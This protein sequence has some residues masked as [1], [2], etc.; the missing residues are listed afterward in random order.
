MTRGIPE[1]EAVA[2]L[3]KQGLEIVD[4]KGKGDCMP[5]ALL[6]Q[7]EADVAAPCE[8]MDSDQLRVM[9]V[10]HL[11]KLKPPE[12]KAE[13]KAE[14]CQFADEGKDSE[15]LWAKT[16]STPGQ[17]CDLRFARLFGLVV[18]AAKLCILQLVQNEGEEAEP[19][20]DWV[21]YDLV[22]RGEGSTVH[23]VHLDDNH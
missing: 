19:K 23:L 10:S 20:I 18:G 13:F 2:Y 17:P 4:N 6:K 11:E 8:G 3:E 22:Q 5:L 21:S 9:V 1:L 12:C 16:M 7:P 15:T 14:Y